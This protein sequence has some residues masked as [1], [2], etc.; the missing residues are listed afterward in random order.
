MA[1]V[2]SAG[3]AKVFGERLK[4]SSSSRAVLQRPA[5]QTRRVECVLAVGVEETQRENDDLIVHMSPRSGRDRARLSKLLMRECG[6]DADCLENSTPTIDDLERAVRRSLSLSDVNEALERQSEQ[7]SPS[8]PV[9]ASLESARAR[10]RGRKSASSNV[11]R[12]QTLNQMAGKTQEVP[13]RRRRN[14]NSATLTDTVIGKSESLGEAK[15]PR[16]GR[17]SAAPESVRHYLAD[18]GQASLLT[19]EEEVA[20]SMCIQVLSPSQLEC[21]ARNGFGI[22]DF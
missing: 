5:V 3:I 15:K 13:S 1:A 9:V 21:S 7:A 17:Q 4:P 2:A 16:R 8:T 6:P 10:R 12:F 18:M 19:A 14:A 22:V 11:V 20:L